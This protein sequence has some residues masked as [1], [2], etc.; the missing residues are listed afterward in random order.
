MTESQLKQYDLFLDENDWDI[1]LGYTNCS[2]RLANFTRVC[3]GLCFQH[4]RLHQHRVQ[5]SGQPCNCERDGCMETECSEIRRMGAN[6]GHFQTG[7]STSSSKMGKQRSFVYA[8]KTC[9]IQECWR[10]TEGCR[11]GTQ[12]Q[13]IWFWSRSDA[14]HSDIHELAVRGDFS[15]CI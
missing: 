9:Q 1:L 12:Q 13:G 14:R 2:G 11:C 7:V 15:I 8:Q 5:L 6:R 3:G 4:T 10:C